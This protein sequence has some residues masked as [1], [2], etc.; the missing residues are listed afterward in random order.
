[1]GQYYSRL[2]QR[3]AMRIAVAGVIGVALWLYHYNC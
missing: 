3:W 1:M 2:A